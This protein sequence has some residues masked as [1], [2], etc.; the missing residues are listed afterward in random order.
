MFF[1][2]G[3]LRAVS[4]PYSLLKIGARAFQGCGNL[5]RLEF[6]AG[7]E[8]SEIGEYAFAGCAALTALRLPG[9]VRRIGTG[10]F[11]GCDNL[12]RI[13]FGE[14]IAFPAAI[15]VLPADAFA[16]CPRLT[17]AVFADGSMLTR[18]GRGAFAR[19]P[20]ALKRVKITGEVREIGACAFRDCAALSEFEMP[21][22]DAVRKIGARAFENCTSLPEAHVP[23][24]LQVIR[25]GTY[26]G[27]VAIVRVK[28]PFGV[29]KIRRR[30]FLECGNLKTATIANADA[31]IARS[32]FPAETKLRRPDPGGEG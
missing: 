1:N 8:L 16:D 5:E 3:A 14:E 9:T 31:I 18:I 12:T 28:I 20:R 21:L 15:S 2:C 27:C 23:D 25:T 26:R 10:A 4:F 17:E 13:E 11:Q 24:A 30:A 22:L 19:L 29:K 7:C 32:A 6:A